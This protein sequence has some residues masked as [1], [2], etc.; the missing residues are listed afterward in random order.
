[1]SR[2]S[3][4]NSSPRYE[5]NLGVIITA[6]TIFGMG[7]GVG[8]IYRNLEAK[9]LEGQNDLKHMND[10]RELKEEIMQLKGDNALLNFQINNIFKNEKK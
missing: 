3:N 6:F 9:I 10:V 1:M 4:T 5:I 2:T 7:F 8:C